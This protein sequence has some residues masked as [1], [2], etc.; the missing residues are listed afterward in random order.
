MGELGFNNG[1]S[2]VRNDPRGAIYSLLVTEDGP[3]PLGYIAALLPEL[4]DEELDGEI[5]KMKEDGIVDFG[6]EGVELVHQSEKND[7]IVEGADDCAGQHN[8]S[9]EQ[10]KEVENSN[11][12]SSMTDSEVEDYFAALFSHDGMTSAPVS[13]SKSSAVQPDGSSDAAKCDRAELENDVDWLLDGDAGTTYSFNS[14]IKRLALPIPNE[15]LIFCNEHGIE[16]VQQLLEANPN[17]YPRFGSVAREKLVQHLREHA[18]H[19]FAMPSWATCATPWRRE[20]APFVFFFNQAGELCYCFQTEAGCSR[21]ARLSSSGCLRPFNSFVDGLAGSIASVDISVLDLPEPVTRVL[22]GHGISS[23]NALM[24]QTDEQL[25]SMKRIGVGTL[26]CVAQALREWLSSNGIQF[27]PYD[28]PLVSNDIAIDGVIRWL[29]E[30]HLPYYE[31]S[32]RS[33]LAE[34]PFDV[35]VY[36][37]GSS[38]INHILCRD[39]VIDAI[40]RACRST[41][42]IW[43]EYVASN[44]DEPLDQ[45]IFLVPQSQ[46]WYEEV[47]NIADQDSCIDFNE[48]RGEISFAPLKVME[49]LDDKRDNRDWAILYHR[50]LGETLDQVG[51]RFDLTRERVRQIEKRSIKALPRFYEDHYAKFYLEYNVTADD[52][53]ELTGETKRVFTYLQLRYDRGCRDQPRSRKPLSQAAHDNSMPSILRKA[54]SSLLHRR[55]LESMVED[56]GEYIPKDRLSILRHVLT[57]IATDGESIRCDDLFEKYQAFLNEHKLGGTK[58]VA[59]SN[60]RAMF[61]WM[62]RRNCFMAPTFRSVRLYDRSAYDF[63]DLADMWADVANYNIECSARLL[64]VLNKGLM[65]TLDI[66]DEYELH[67][68]SQVE[69]KDSIEGVSFSRIPVVKL[70]EADRHAQILELIRELAPVS[71]SDLSDE[72]ERRYGIDARTFK[73]SFLGDFKQYKI[74]NG[75]DIG[76]EKLSRDEIDFLAE[77]LSGIEY[78]SLPYVRARFQGRFPEKPSILVGESALRQL[79]SYEQQRAFTIS[80]Q[81]I[82]RKDLRLNDAFKRLIASRDMFSIDDEGIGSDVFSHSAFQSELKK[83]LRAVEIVECRP[84]TYYSTNWIRREFGIT[85]ETLLDYRKAVLKVMPHDEPFNIASLRNRGFYHPVDIL[86]EES[87]FGTTPLESILS[88]GT[89]SSRLA[90]CSMAEVKLFSKTEKRFTANTV[91]DW[92]VARERAVELEDLIDIFEEEFDVHLSKPFLRESFKRCAL[93]YKMALET[94]FV[95]NDAYLQYRDEYL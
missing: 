81:L 6:T 44:L 69:L 16:T 30:Q 10:S 39:N 52:F 87:G 65:E 11:L 62:Q 53:M 45:L 20:Y 18:I 47:Q 21:S 92:I 17:C 91:I 72:Y 9:I 14:Q 28:E 58:E 83:A 54:V 80:E 64:F 56:N 95:S 55:K 3:C 23:V 89:G 46:I 2:S 40:R 4:S 57:G 73:A 19:L 22:R 24:E 1:G 51:K 75:Y 38:D 41:V 33:W 36:E 71:E 26:E 88:T 94:V 31:L 29:N 15:T 32:M 8:S 74:G 63:V 78:I 12:F 61:A 60:A 13:T 27:N 85:R 48:S 70:G 37:G 84:G 79:A 35:S 82:V 93:T 67:W 86:C 76:Y 49:W 90:T 68:I 43:R 34:E 25:L 42:R 5:T 77:E 59:F 7:D 66:R 50:I